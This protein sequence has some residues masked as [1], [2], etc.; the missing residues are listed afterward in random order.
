VKDLTFLDVL[1][2]IKSLKQHCHYLLFSTTRP[3][4]NQKIEQP[5]ERLG[6]PRTPPYIPT[7]LSALVR[8]NDTVPEPDTAFAGKRVLV[9]AG[10]DDKL[11]PRET[12]GRF[13]VALVGR[14]G[15]KE[16]MVVPGVKHEFTNGMREEVFRFSWEEALIRAA[17]L[18]CAL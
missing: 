5:S 12:S 2:Y 11:V 16:V 17:V 18:I 14:G 1:T 15:R 10:A 7:S 4:L 6:V 13:V 8:A 3:L 9:L